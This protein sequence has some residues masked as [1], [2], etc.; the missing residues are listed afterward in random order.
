M[1]SLVIAAFAL[2][3]APLAGATEIAVEAGFRNQS[4]STSTANLNGKSQTGYQLGV[5]ALMP[6]SELWHFRTGLFYVQRPLLLEDTSL[7]PG[8]AKIGMN[9]FEVPVLLAYKMEGYAHLFAGTALSVKLD[10]TLS[11]SG[12]QAAYQLTDVKD[13]VTPLLLGA[14][15]R[16]SPQ[17]GATLFFESITGDVAKDVNGYRAVGVNLT[18]AID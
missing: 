14:S 8:E 12:S 1:R 10:S 18:I 2:F 5:T 16:F 7:I 3:F 11:R 9:Y 13:L 6:I 4:G 15:F 17:L